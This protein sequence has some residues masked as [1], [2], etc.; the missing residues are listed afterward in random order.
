MANYS[1]LASHSQGKSEVDKIF[2]VESA[3]NEKAKTLE[4]KHY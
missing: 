2:G 3:A 1:V 4:R